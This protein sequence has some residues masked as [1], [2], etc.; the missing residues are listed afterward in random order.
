[1]LMSALRGRG[2]ERGGER[3]KEREGEGGR[4]KERGKGVRGSMKWRQS[5]E[6]LEGQ[7]S[8]YRVLRLKGGPRSE[9][10]VKVSLCHPSMIIRIQGPCG[11]KRCEVRCPAFAISQSHFGILLRAQQLT[12]FQSRSNPPKT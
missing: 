11:I 8:R 4:E 6:L 12:L 9:T 7:R 10:R 1:M 2:G 5:L 3:G